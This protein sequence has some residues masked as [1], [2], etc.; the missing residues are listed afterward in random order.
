M[1]TTDI[2]TDSDGNA[3]SLI[4]SAGDF[5]GLATWEQLRDSIDASPLGWISHSSGLS[6][7][8]D[9][10]EDEMRSLLAA[11]DAANA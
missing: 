2:A 3:F 5:A 4:N 1:N 11:Y 10:N 7:Y 6:V 8:V 9:G